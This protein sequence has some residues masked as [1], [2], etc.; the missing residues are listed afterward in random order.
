[1]NKLP[2]TVKQYERLR[3]GLRVARFQNRLNDIVLGLLVV[4]GLLASWFVMIMYI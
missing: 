1:M 3:K 4:L 2:N